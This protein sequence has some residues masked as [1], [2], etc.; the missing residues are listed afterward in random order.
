MKKYIFTICAVL[1]A[2]SCTKNKIDNISASEG[3]GRLRLSSGIE[4]R[5]VGNE[6]EAEDAISVTMYQAGTTTP[7]GTPASK[8]LAEKA[9]A[10]VDFNPASEDEALYFPSSGTVDIAAYYPYQ[11]GAGDILELIVSTNDDIP[12]VD[13]LW[14][15]AENVSKDDEVLDLNFE[16]V[17]SKISIKLVPGIGLSEEELAGSTVE[18]YNV[19]SKAN[20]D[21]SSG[22]LTVDRFHPLDY[23]KLSG[24]TAETSGIDREA[25]ILPQTVVNPDFYIIR[26]G[27]PFWVEAFGDFVFESG[28]KHR[29][30]IEVSYANIGFTGKVID[31]RVDSESDLV[32][33]DLLYLSKIDKDNIPEGDVW[34]IHDATATSEDFEGLRTVLDNEKTRKIELI[35]PSLTEIPE[36]ALNFKE[37]DINS[38][39][40]KITAPNVEKL[41]ANA[42]N[43]C[44]ALTEVSLPAATM[45]GAQA[46][47]YCTTL[48]NLYIGY[49]AKSGKHATLTSID[50]TWLYNVDD[51]TKIT[52]YTGLWSEVDSNFS[53]SGN[54][55]TLSDDT[56]QIFS[57]IIQAE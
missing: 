24:T 56:E 41:G 22:E 9:G 57:Q 1:V 52:L 4:T 42:I 28:K 32:L 13:L 17:L 15:K 38:S 3:D 55:L 36:G 14:A 7:I 47:T 48:K 51:L 19:R 33:D 34:T 21:T 11:E 50:P 31:W 27:E 2:A 37:Y 35:F 53:V 6:W 49:D 20:F 43:S 12:E 18:V 26:N 23:I 39:L 8:Y 10:K 54:T 44:D 46:F 5:V 25:F 40:T 16:H 30:T 29:F 45:I